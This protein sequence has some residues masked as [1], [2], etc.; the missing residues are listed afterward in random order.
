MST[1]DPGGGGAAS[2]VARPIIVHVLLPVLG[3]G[4]GLLVRWAAAWIASLPFAPFQGV[5]ELLEALP[6]PGSTI[7][8]G[9]VG[10]VGGLVLAFLDH[11]HALGLAVS[12]DRAVLRRTG[13]TEEVDRSEV[14]GVFLEPKAKDGG[15]LDEGRLVLLGPRTEELVRVP[16]DLNAGEV[17]RAFT[18]HG[19]PWL[20]SDPYRSGFKRWVDGLPELSAKANALLKARAEALEADGESDAEELRRELLSVGVVVRDEKK[21]QYWRPIPDAPGAGE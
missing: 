20:E 6:E 10:G 11:H 3:V 7:A 18:G 12:A 17:R 21:R 5:F 16:C 2:V 15:F 8:A 13:T 14:H 4:V 9:A 19:W 1:H